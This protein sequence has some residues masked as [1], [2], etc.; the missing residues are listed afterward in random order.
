MKEKQET[1]EHGFSVGKWIDF[2][3]LSE[4]EQNL[5]FGNPF[6]DIARQEKQTPSE[7]TFTITAID[8]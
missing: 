7:Q 8:L 1:K 6:C 3:D 2:K 4:E 5:V